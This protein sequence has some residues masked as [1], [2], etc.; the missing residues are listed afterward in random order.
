MTTITPPRDTSSRSSEDD[1][2]PPVKLRWTAPRLAYKTSW[3]W[4]HWALT[5]AIAIAVVVGAVMDAQVMQPALAHILRGNG[6]HVALICYVI[7][8]FARP[9][10]G[11]R[12]S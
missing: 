12:P 2:A 10:Q 4:P 6:S 3:G 8:F 11:T 7:R 1:A 9:R 5:I